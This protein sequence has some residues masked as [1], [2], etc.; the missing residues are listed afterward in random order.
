MNEP[1]IDVATDPRTDTRA[2]APCGSGEPIDVL[3]R[4]SNR[5][6]RAETSFRAAVRPPALSNA[7]EPRWS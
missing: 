1:V 5:L 2:W 6:H 3:R 7:M 4:T